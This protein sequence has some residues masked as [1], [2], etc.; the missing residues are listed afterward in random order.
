MKLRSSLFYA[1]VFLISCFLISPVFAQYKAKTNSAL[2]A[3]KRI[4]PGIQ[5]V[6]I[7]PRSERPVWLQGSVAQ[8]FN[9]ENTSQVEEFMLKN[10]QVFGVLNEGNS[11]KVKRTRKDALG[12][13][14]SRVQ[15]LYKGVPVFG[16]EMILHGDQS[17]TIELMNGQ[18]VGDIAM[19]IMPQLSPERAI[20]TAQNHLGAAVYRWEVAEM[21]KIIK[22]A[23]NDDLRTWKPQPELVISAVN[24]QFLGDDFRLTYKLML[25][26]E[27][28]AANW[29]YFI[30][31]KTGEVVNRWNSMHATTATGSGPSL[32]SGTVS[33]QTE[34][35]GTEFEMYDAVRN[36]K[37]YD[38]NNGT[39]LPGTLYT[40][41][42]NF[43]DAAGHAAAVET[44]WGSMNFYDYYSNVHGRNSIDGAGMQI[45]GSV[46]YSS[47]YNN[48]SWDG[49]QAR[50]GD[51]D[52]VQFDPLVTIDIAAHEF[53]HGVTDFESN[54]VYQSEPG[55]LNE[56]L[57][58]MFGI[59]VDFYARPGVANWQLGEECYTPG[60]PG[61]AL[62]FMND[63]NLAS[64]PD[65]YEG[66]FWAPTAN[67]SPFNDWGGVHTNSGVPN[68][69]FYLLSEG[70]S[71]TNDNGT[72]YSVA[73]ITIDKAAKIWYRA[74]TTYLTTNSQFADAR[75][76]TLSSAEDLYGAASAEYQ[77]V[78][79]AWIAVGVGDGGGTNSP[80]TASIDSPTNGQNFASGAQVNFSGSATDTD[81]TVAVSTYKW[82]INGPGIPPNYIFANGQ[83]NPSGVPPADGNYTVTLEVTDNDG[84]TGTATVDFT[85]GGAANQPPTAVANANPTSGT[86]PLAVNFTGSGSSDPDGSITSYS[87]DFGD[88]NSSSTAD[89][90]HTY[91]N[92]GNYTAVLTVTDND[93]ATDTDQV[94]INVTG[95]GGNTPPVATI[96][97]PA[98][99]SSYSVGATVNFSGT[100]T[101]AEDGTLPASAFTWKYTYNGGPEVT[102]QTGVKSGSGVLIAPGTFK[103]ILIVEDSQSVTDRD[104]VTVT[105]SGGGATL[106]G[107][108]SDP[109]MLSANVPEAI[110]VFSSYPNPFNP[111]TNIYFNLI[112]R[113]H[114]NLAIYNIMGQKIRTLADGTFES[115]AQNFTWD[116]RNS[117][118][119]I[120]T[121]GL[122]YA[123]LVSNGQAQTIKLVM[124]K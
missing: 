98:N 64:D 38:A 52:G 108:N 5:R 44:H 82:S 114:V 10:Q 48:A 17:G 116:G 16:S 107:L 68:F 51:G 41:A 42:D 39:N 104:E 110:D 81:G 103:I 88:G 23:F 6:E 65:T 33:I 62:R 94:T 78:L 93:G 95:G 80:P 27:E 87:W 30:D 14:H 3:A 102:F 124:M 90:S 57:S 66:D 106:A 29:T 18:L 50:F 55:A 35:T 69:H 77:A 61:D 12:M 119:S 75:N 115:G 70:G 8:N 121:S 11:F 26:T 74:Q 63:P 20:Q 86:A 47:N 118:G 7:N 100:G 123:R 13:I 76:A 2:A 122:Y 92:S 56:S 24:G 120:M 21:E 83:A 32:Y 109:F 45:I 54:L 31:A 4:L 73:A 25:P 99:G 1:Y 53:T 91:N 59:S 58:D 60:T 34:D 97:S 85:V 96:T 37:T 40:D 19:D 112:S 72:N 79:D 46:H 89:P 111:E 67:P 43:W 15:H 113:Q 49:V 84:A 36:I 9:L 101:D 71:G 117:T 105:A 22:M 28:P